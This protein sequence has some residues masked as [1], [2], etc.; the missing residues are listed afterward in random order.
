MRTFVTFLYLQYSTYRVSYE[1]SGVDAHNT[2]TNTN[3]IFRERESRV[4]FF[5][6]SQTHSLAHN[7]LWED[8]VNTQ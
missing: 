3:R 2:H 7:L 8:R 1:R 4:L 5:I 6:L